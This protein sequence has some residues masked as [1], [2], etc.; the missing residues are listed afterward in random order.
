MD[1]EEAKKCVAAKKK[2]NDSSDDETTSNEENG[3][4]ETATVSVLP[5]EEDSQDLYDDDM[6]LLMMS[7]LEKLS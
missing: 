4:L 5:K 2:A 3:A 1:I 6:E 7:V